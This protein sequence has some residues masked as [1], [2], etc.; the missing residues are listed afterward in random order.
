M[1]RIKDFMLMGATASMM[2]MTTGCDND[3]YHYNPNNDAEVLQ[4]T[5]FAENFKAK[6]GD[7]SP[8]QT[9]DFVGNSAICKLPGMETRATRAA[10]TPI[11][12]TSDGF[13]F[14]MTDDFIAEAGVKFQDFGEKTPAYYV[15]PDGPLRLTQ[16]YQGG[17][18]GGNNN[19]FLHMIVG[20]GDDTQ[21]IVVASNN[22]GINMNQKAG[23]TTTITGIPAG[24]PISF[25]LE[26]HVGSKIYYYNSLEGNP[27]QMEFSSTIGAYRDGTVIGEKNTVLGCQ[28]AVSSSGEFSNIAYLVD[29]LSEPQPAPEK[30]EKIIT[31]RYMVED[32]GD[33]DDFDFNDIVIDVQERTLV[34]NDVVLEREQKATL[35]HLGGSLP[36]NV[37]IGNTWFA[38]SESDMREGKMYYDTEETISIQGWNP[39]ENNLTVVVARTGNIN[40][41]VYTIPF[42]KKGAAP[43]IVAVANTLQWM[44]ER[45]AVPEDWWYMY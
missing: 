20:T 3:K 10:I 21:D 36:W 31:K 45:V 41:G 7:I 34:E 16:V 5:A 28:A 43:M 11:V 2:L 42:P 22:Q 9:W 15:M 1:K 38:G 25:Y 12:E 4:K 29:G 13:N 40:D 39:E 19:F 14:D 35:V 17:L 27:K 37:K 26:A 18:K 23:K 32:L 44:E 30:I 24:T 6:Y 33:I 8:D